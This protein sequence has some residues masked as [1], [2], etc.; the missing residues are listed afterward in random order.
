M[1]TVSTQNCF[2]CLYNDLLLN[3]SLIYLS[4]L[5]NGEEMPTVQLSGF[6]ILT[7]NI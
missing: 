6:L 3:S 7:I 4:D 1:H 2:Y 5:F